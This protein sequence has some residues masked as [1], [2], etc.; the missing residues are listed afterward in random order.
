[1]RTKRTTRNEAMIK[2][3]THGMKKMT[4]VMRAKWWMRTKWTTRTG[5]M[6]NGLVSDTHTHTHTH[7]L[8]LIE[9]W[10]AVVVNQLSVVPIAVL[11][12]SFPWGVR[13]VRRLPDRTGLLASSL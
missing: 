4:S 11:P 7:K 3:R 6:T 8:I 10:V 5:T 2:V 1:M 9:I 12:T 13:G